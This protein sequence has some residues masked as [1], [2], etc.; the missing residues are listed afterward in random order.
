[1]ARGD[2]P[3][4]R[5]PLALYDLLLTIVVLFTLQGDTITSTPLDVARIAI[6]LLVRFGL[7]GSGALAAGLRLGIGY[8]RIASIRLHDLPDDDPLADMAKA[9]GR[10]SP[11]TILR[12]PIA[13]V[14]RHATDQQE[15]NHRELTMEITAKPS[16]PTG[17]SR[18]LWRLPIG[19]YRIGLGR[20][21]G[22]R[23]LLLRHTG[24]SSG[25]QRQAVLEIIA[26]DD[27]GWT[28][29]SGFGPRSNW[30]RNVTAHPEVTIQVGATE[31]QATAT[32]L[33]PDESAQLMVDYA[34]HHPRAARRLTRFLGY[35]VD[36]TDDDWAQVGRHLPLVRFE[37]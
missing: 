16:P 10:P 2:L 23:F 30:Y 21:L 25:L 22:S 9:L 37:R 28:V 1:V 8:E 4:S 17:I 3:D 19:L 7:M 6:P 34:N 13:A 33:D 15:S 12:P 18:L 11:I 31:H 14:P 24:R 29:A 27:R 35:R 36:G 5:R 32:T 26:R 20:L